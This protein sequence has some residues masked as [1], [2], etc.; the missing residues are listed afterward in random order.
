MLSLHTSPCRQRFWW[1]SFCL[2][3][4][5]LGKSVPNLLF[6]IC[7][8]PLKITKPWSSLSLRLESFLKLLKQNSLNQRWALVK[9][10][11]A[12]SQPFCCTAK[13]SSASHQ[14]DWLNLLSRSSQ[15]ALPNIWGMIS[16]AG[17]KSHPSLGPQGQDWRA[18]QESIAANGCWLWSQGWPQPFSMLGRPNEIRN[19]FPC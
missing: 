4:G 19:V 9:T 1:G 17:N 10:K 3:T 2:L 6:P 8:L 16:W 13:P 15:D 12:Y 7:I 18:D 5:F 11:P 14:L